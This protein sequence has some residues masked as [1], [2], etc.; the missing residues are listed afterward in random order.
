VF[1]DADLATVGRMLGDGHRA[2]FLL[3]LLGGEE[4]TAG[5]LARRSGASSSLASSHLSKLLDAG[6]VSVRQDGRRRRYRL[7]G[8]EVARALEALLAIAPTRP[9]SGLRDSV[10]GDAIKRAR[11]C[12]DHLAGRLGIGLVD[13]ME[14]ERLLDP[15]AGS[16][17]ITARGEQRLVDLDLDLD[18]LRRSRRPLLRPCPDWTERRPHVARALGA[19]IT[20]RLIDDRWIERLPGSRAVR[21]TERGER[22]LLSHFGL[23]V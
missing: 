21:V 23:R 9:A 16:W 15:R 19:A 10:R 12:Y 8:D 18:G 14:R 1:A 6:L 22:R 17:E 13:A 2:R 3:A 5:E 11:T 20:D 7:P 4:L